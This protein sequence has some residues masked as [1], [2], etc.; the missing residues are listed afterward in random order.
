M[1]EEKIHRADDLR[2]YPVDADHIVEPDLGLAGT[3][4]EVG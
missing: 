3:D 1:R 4:H 2:L